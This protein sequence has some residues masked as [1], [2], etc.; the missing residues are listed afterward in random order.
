MLI[1]REAERVAAE[2]QEIEKLEERAEWLSIER[3]DTTAVGLLFCEFQLKLNDE[4]IAFR[5]TY[6]DAF[7]SLPPYIKPVNPEL[8]LS[9]QHQWGPGGELCLQFRPDHWQPE[10][11]SVQVLESAHTLLSGGTEDAM[12]MAL[13]SAYD[14]ALDLL[15]AERRFVLPPQSEAA[16]RQRIASS[17]SIARFTHE[18]QE[19]ICVVR[20]AT[21]GGDPDHHVVPSDGRGEAVALRRSV[22]GL[23]VRLP[24]IIRI[25][26]MSVGTLQA[27]VTLRFMHADNIVWSGRFRFVLVSDGRTERLFQVAKVDDDVEVAEHM[28]VRP[29]TSAD[30]IGLRTPLADKR[31]CVIGCGSLGSK[32]AAT[33]TREGVGAFSLLDPDVLWSDNLVRNELDERHVGHHKAKALAE[34]LRELSRSVT[35]SGYAF[36]LTSQTPVELMDEIRG[37]VTNCDLI[38]DATAEAGAF[39]ALAPLAAASKTP[40]VWGRIYAGGIGGMIARSLPDT[41]PPPR[42]AAAQIANWCAAQDRLVPDGPARNYGIDGEDGPLIASETDVAVVAM[43]MARHALDALLPTAERVHTEPV[44]FIGMRGGW[45]FDNAFDVHPVTYTSEGGLGSD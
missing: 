12:E 5:L 13:P 11:T 6:P 36:G 17:I 9:K 32:I 43:H 1:L 23:V 14:S 35:V 29:P 22:V 25:E 38:I 39:N 20:L 30:R 16:V 2:L 19:G 7:P 40:L 18:W 34:R 41:D 26:S 42:H 27:F 28:T 10:W 4:P 45:I 8:W 44:Y 33:L 21:L 37:L 31:V 15:N 24:E 3:W